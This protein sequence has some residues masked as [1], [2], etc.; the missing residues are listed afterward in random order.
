[1][2]GLPVINR[3]ANDRPTMTGATASKLPNTAAACER[4]KAAIFAS[5]SRKPSTVSSSPICAASAGAVTA[6]CLVASTPPI[7]VMIKKLAA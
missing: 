5:N 7:A 4:S 1:M 2:T 6:G 3:K